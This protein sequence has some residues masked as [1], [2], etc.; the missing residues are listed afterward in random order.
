[1]T[2]DSL[3]GNRAFDSICGTLSVDQSVSP[4]IGVSSATE[5]ADSL[6]FNFD[7]TA[8]SWTVVN[9]TSGA[10]KV[11]GPADLVASPPAGV[12]AYATPNANGRNDE[13]F[14]RGPANLGIA[15][16]YVRVADFNRA[17]APN[18]PGFFAAASSQCAFGVPTLAGEVFPSGEFNFP[19]LKVRAFAIRKVGGAFD[20]PIEV[21]DLSDSTGT[22]RVN[23]LSG[24]LLVTLDLKGRL[25]NA[26]GS[27]SATVKQ[28]PKLTEGSGT[29]SSIVE[30]KGVNRIYR[31][32]FTTD[33]ISGFDFY[34]GW[35]FGP[36]GREAGFS[37][38]SRP[39]P[40]LDSSQ[41]D[42]S[43]FK[44]AGAVIAKR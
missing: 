39:G 34:A 22:M 38:E 19:E 20:D 6:D 3:T 25:V 36:A 17:V 44:I 16:Q 32:N 1:M 41:P 28:F 5:F 27:L 26:D 9:P 30:T 43:D 24:Q 31:G 42:L 18:T 8:N 35:F 29:I 14:F 33:G 23:Y 15:T 7:A 40:P 37:F 11:F 13:L 2:Y 21:Y 10:S 12:V 4:P